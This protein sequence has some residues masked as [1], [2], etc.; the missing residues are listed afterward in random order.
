M[1]R[2]LLSGLLFLLT[3]SALAEDYTVSVLP[4]YAPNEVNERAK[5][6]ASYLNEVT[7]LNIT[8]VVTAAFPEYEARIQH[9]D[10]SLGFENPYIY[11][12]AAETRDVIAMAMT[13]KDGPKL[14]GVIITRA[15]SDIVTLED[16]RGKRIAIAGYSAAG[17]YLS[18]K[19][20]M[21]EA[22]IDVDKECQVTEALYNKH[23]NVIMSVYYGD[24]DAGFVRETALT[25]V[26]EYVPRSQ[27]N[28][29]GKGAWLPNWSFSVADS[30]SE[31]DRT[32]IRDALVNIPT[33]SPLLKTL[34]VT[35]FQEA[36]DSD[37][38][39]IRKA[40][41]MPIPERAP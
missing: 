29:M 11:I 10:I 27:I 5:A 6:L 15:G 34:K 37:Y 30:V 33:G 14:Q 39:S 13:G 4:R 31:A 2:I 38:D 40:A 12:R 9:G 18:Q 20:A 1:T 8:P 19:L 32:A 41:E 23:E 26:A 3:S 17:G 21:M 36:Q 25:E 22:G 35:G 28:I 7:N 24:V 16:L